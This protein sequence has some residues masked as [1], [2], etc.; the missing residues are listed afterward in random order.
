MTTTPDASRT[1]NDLLSL[2][3]AA[4]VRWGNGDPTG[5]LELYAPDISYF[6]PLTAARIDGRQAMEEYYRPWT[7]KI[8]IARF[9]FIN[10]QIVIDGAMAL[11][12][13]N[14]INYSRDSAGHEAVAS[15]WN[16]TSVYHRRGDAWQLIHS[17]WS[18]TKHAAF[19]NLTAEANAGM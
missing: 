12:T 15:R 6:D 10:P 16:N 2:E 5:L 9:E 1:A 17:H 8:R 7:G 13:Y 18:F 4:L 3:R 14:L 19:E 11:V